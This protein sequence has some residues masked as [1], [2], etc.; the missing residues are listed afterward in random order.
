M[1]RRDFLVTA[2]SVAGG[3]ALAN[4][5][6][7]EQAIVK[8]AARKHRWKGFN[9]L[10]KFTANRN[11]PFQER[12]F[13]WMAGWGFDFIRLPMDYRAWTD[14]KDPKKLDEKTL[15][16]IDQA[17]EWGKQYNVHVNVNLHRAPGYCVNPPAEPLNLWES[18]EALDQFCFQWRQFSERYK[19]YSSEQVSFNLINEPGA[20]A[21][22]KYE[23]VVRAA[24]KEIRAISPDRLILIDGLRWG[25]DPMLSLVDLKVA[26]STHNY[27]PMRLTHYKASWVRGSD[28]WPEPTWPLK[29]NDKVWDKERLREEMVVPW[30]KLEELKIFVHVG[31]WGAFNQTPHA[32]VL[33]W[34]T[35][36]LSLWQETGWG[37][38]LWNFRGS[39]GII[40]SGRKDVQYETFQ[41]R[42][43]DRKML[44]L[45]RTGVE[46]KA[47]TK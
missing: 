16:E 26:R 34:M 17:V 12:D 25:R 24:V 36:L 35:D 15:K 20:M 18:D 2:A 31:K 37:W 28:Q 6:H 13:E 9:L 38:A 43:L 19:N 47:T 22:E 21:S 4:E 41:G 32:V 39:F 11:R 30:K 29:E 23:K 44:E 10:E 8:S 5:A 42:M 27:D 7:S 1:K 14:S 33:A 3:I 45:L 40:D 46:A